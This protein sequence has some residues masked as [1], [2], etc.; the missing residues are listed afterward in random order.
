MN[1]GAGNQA[2]LG[3]RGEG[4]ASVPPI[5]DGAVVLDPCVGF[6]RALALAHTDAQRGVEPASSQ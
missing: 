4:L 1:P 5:E 2:G 6:H 3:E